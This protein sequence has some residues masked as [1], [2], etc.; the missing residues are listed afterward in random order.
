MNQLA[1]LAR[2]L[3]S[4]GKGIFASDAS[5]KTVDKF[6]KAYGLSGETVEERR[7]Y[8][9]VLYTAPGLGKYVGGVIMHDEAIRQRTGDGLSF[10]ELLKNAGMVPGIK[11]DRGTRDMA[12]FPG[13]K[14]SEGLDGLRERLQEY[15]GLGARFTKWR[16]V[17]T[18]GEGTPTRQNIVSN[19]HTLA[20]YAALSQECG[21][22]PIVEPEI[23]MDGTH[24]IEKCAEVTESVSRTVFEILLDQ[25]VDPTA[26]LYKTNM[27]VMGKGATTQVS[28][29][30][31]GRRTV[32]VL[33]RTVS[34]AVPGVVF[35]SGGQDSLAA[36]RRLNEI[37]RAGAGSPWRWTFS[38]E[39]A[40]EEPV[41]KTWLG[42]DEHKAL[43]QKE[44]LKR[45]ELNSLAS[46]GMYQGE[47]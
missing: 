42:K 8:R 18:I 45:A 15:Y 20:R 9:E 31:V 21:L 32:E 12:G 33:K 38:F 1:Q 11:V 29:E 14:I 47:H 25:R 13:E 30:E 27:V 23:L 26:L 10:V 43:A 44:L 24:S 40:F 5:E 28:D 37:A 7:R 39:R 34:V 6:L 3:V 41:I 19:A 4:N 2:D 22:V 36:T 16:A 17:I 35:L 46:M